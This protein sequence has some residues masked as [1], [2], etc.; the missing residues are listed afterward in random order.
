MQH[1]KGRWL[2]VILPICVVKNEVNAG[3]LGHKFLWLTV[4][5]FAPSAATSGPAVLLLWGS[6]KRKRAFS[7]DVLRQILTRP[8]TYIL[9]RNCLRS[10]SLLF[11]SFSLV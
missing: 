1:D 6:V 7:A 8:L 5:I 10:S 2:Y 11:G 3:C 9:L 4:F